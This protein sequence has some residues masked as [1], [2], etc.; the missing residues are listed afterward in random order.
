MKTDEDEGNEIEED[1]DEDGLEDG[2][3]TQADLESQNL[4]FTQLFAKIAGVLDQMDL[5]LPED[6]D[7]DL[8]DGGDEEDE[9]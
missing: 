4:E 5:N 1:E 8:V 3:P 2:E 6:E 9:L 7:D